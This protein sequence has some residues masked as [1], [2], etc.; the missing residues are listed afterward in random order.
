[1]AKINICGIPKINGAGQMKYLAKEAFNN[2]LCQLKSEGVACH[3]MMNCA[4]QNQIGKHGI[5]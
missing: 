1:L 2:Q 4:S 5:Q 3:S